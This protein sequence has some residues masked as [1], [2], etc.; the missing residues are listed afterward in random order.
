MFN[1]AQNS[2]I[3]F[4]FKPLDREKKCKIFETKELLQP[5]AR[6]KSS[7][8]MSAEERYSARVR[9]ISVAK[10]SKSK[11][12]GSRCELSPLYYILCF[13][14][15]LVCVDPFHRSS[16]LSLYYICVFISCGVYYS[17]VS[18]FSHGETRSTDGVCSFPLCVCV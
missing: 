8:S 17:R 6:D 3:V 2:P 1:P 7:L 18:C 13:S 9:G 12:A 4:F 10:D 15:S 11:L 5:I 14:L 16:E